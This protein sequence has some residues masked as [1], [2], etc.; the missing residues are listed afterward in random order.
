MDFDGVCTLLAPAK[1]E[2]MHYIWELLRKCPRQLEPLNAEG[3]QNA[4]L[5]ETDIA[6][7]YKAHILEP[8]TAPVHTFGSAFTVV[9]EKKGTLRRRFILW[10]KQANQWLE[11]QGYVSAVD[12][13]TQP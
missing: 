4:R 11:E 6:A 8:C 3:P 2:R 7:L 5:P 10:P 1:L 12:L 9:E 13:N